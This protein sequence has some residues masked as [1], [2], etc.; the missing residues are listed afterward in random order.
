[1]CDFLCANMR[2]NRMRLQRRLRLRLEILAAHRGMRFDNESNMCFDLKDI[3][4]IQIFSSCNPY[5]ELHKTELKSN[6]NAKYSNSR[7]DGNDLY[8][9][10]C[11]KIISKKADKTFSNL[12]LNSSL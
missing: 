11:V 8:R 1:M 10:D 12:S 6:L 5:N 9:Y 2:Q 7:K 3:Q 4:M